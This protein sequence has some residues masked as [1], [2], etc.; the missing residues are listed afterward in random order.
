MLCDQKTKVRLRTVTANTASSWDYKVFQVA[1][2]EEVTA[3]IEF[4]TA[5][6][7]RRR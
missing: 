6:Q 1:Q 5:A 2:D 3:Q 4:H 7:R